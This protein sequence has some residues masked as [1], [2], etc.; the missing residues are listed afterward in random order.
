MNF[1]IRVIESKNPDYPV[2][3]TVFGNFG[4]RTLTA[5]NPKKFPNKHDL[6]ILPDLGDLSPSI[7]L[8]A[9]GNPG[10]SAY[11]GFLEIC[12]P[13]KGEVVVISAAAGAVGQIVGQIAKIKGCRVIGFAGSD[14]K[15]KKLEEDL[16]FDK[17]LNYKN[18]NIDKLLKEAAPNG[19]DCYFDNVGGTLSSIVIDQM[20]MYGRIS[21]CGAIT[22]YNDKTV[23]VPAF[24]TFH[25]RNLRMEGFMNYRWINKWMED[26]M[27]KM[28]EWIREGK[29][30]C[31]EA[32]TEG[33]ENT[34][35]AFID[36][37]NGKN[38]GKAIVNIR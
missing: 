12:Q 4:W 25:R 30:K 23:M 26:G 21:I 27:L 17:A 9:L 14:E 36:M 18:E 33:F 7:G 3:S 19:I 35:Q 28:L 13:K 8:G 20:R 29:I 6:Y 32:M 24:T 37:F 22:S 16:G 31:Y 10:N 34:P 5:V 11:Y 2:G 38:F 15:C 1:I